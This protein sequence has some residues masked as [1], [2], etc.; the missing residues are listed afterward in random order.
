V[1]EVAAAVA[2]AVIT[3]GA[4]S[5]GA[6]NRRSTEGRE[7]I[8]RL[9]AAVENVAF[10][11]DEIHGDIRADRKETYSRLNNLEVRVTKLEASQ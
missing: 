10:R 7:A 6:S 9:T 3:A 2:G 8:I 1:I 11:L 4:M 5:F